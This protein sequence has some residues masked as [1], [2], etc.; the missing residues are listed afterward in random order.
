[1][2]RRE[3]RREGGKEPWLPKLAHL[4]AAGCAGQCEHSGL[5]GFHQQNSL[6]SRDRCW[7]ASNCLGKTPA[8]SWDQYRTFT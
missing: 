1:M 6:H 4:S 7:S 3:G 2:A 8:V 5:Q